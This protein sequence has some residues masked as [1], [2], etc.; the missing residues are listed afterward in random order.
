MGV[1]ADPD[2]GYTAE[3]E[4]TNSTYL[5]NFP[6]RAWRALPPQGPTNA[7]EPTFRYA[8]VAAVTGDRLVVVGGQ[9]V[10]QCPLQHGR[11]FESLTARP[12]PL[13]C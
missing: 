12:A 5:F 4:V 8:H 11:R 1:I 10:R 9:D 13:V 2:G 3:L 6:S 7:L